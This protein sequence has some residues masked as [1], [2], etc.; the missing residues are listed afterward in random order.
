VSVDVLT[1]AP[2]FAISRVEPRWIADELERRVT[3][4]W[5][6]ETVR[7]PDDVF[8]GLI[9]SVAEATP[10]SIRF[11]ES[12]YRYFLAQRRDPE[13]RPLLDIRP[14]AASGSWRRPGVS[15]PPAAIQLA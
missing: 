5:T 3:S 6:S 14:L 12:R 9:C 1:P 8:D 7:R 10:A 15:I 13:L 2:G 11:F 4:I